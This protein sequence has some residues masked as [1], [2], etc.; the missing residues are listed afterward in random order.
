MQ[1]A[2]APQVA[3]AAVPVVTSVPKNPLNHVR[4]GD[5]RRRPPAMTRN[6]PPQ[7]GHTDRS[8][9]NTRR[10]LSIHVSGAVGEPSGDPVVEPS[11][12]P[13]GE[14]VGKPSRSAPPA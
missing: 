14:P 6:R 13:G 2:I 12:E 9:A 3:P 10:N 8:I 11:G 1:L 5:I 4:I 7:C